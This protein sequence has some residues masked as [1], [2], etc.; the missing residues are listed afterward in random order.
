MHTPPAPPIDAAPGRAGGA[1]S[2][3]ERRGQQ[4]FQAT[5]EAQATLPLPGS[6][7]I[8]AAASRQAWN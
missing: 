6:S 8:A 4:R 7:T 3:Q 2:A 1:P 5:L